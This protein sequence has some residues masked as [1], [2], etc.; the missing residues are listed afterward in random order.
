[1]Q[2]EFV[3]FFVNAQPLSIDFVSIRKR[4]REMITV[5]LGCPVKTDYVDVSVRNKIKLNMEF[6]GQHERV[7]SINASC[8]V[9][10]GSIRAR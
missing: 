5:P 8:S 1:M 4:K 7:D 9:P 2:P 6:G 10:L 3:Y